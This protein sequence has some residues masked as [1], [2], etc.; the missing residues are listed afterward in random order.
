MRELTLVVN[1]TGYGALADFTK[2]FRIEYERKVRSLRFSV[3]TPH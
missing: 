1:Q 2:V 3:V